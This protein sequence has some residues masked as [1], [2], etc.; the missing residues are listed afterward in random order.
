MPTRAGKIERKKKEKIGV[1]KK[2][3]GKKIKK[4]IKKEKKKEKGEKP[5]IIIIY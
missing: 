4:G 3:K 1:D 5:I 2:G